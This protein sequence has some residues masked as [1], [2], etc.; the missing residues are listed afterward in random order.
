MEENKN[1]NLKTNKIYFITTFSIFFLIFDYFSKNYLKHISMKYFFS[2]DTTR[3]DYFIYSD[4]FEEGI[5]YLMYYIAYNFINVYCSIFMIAMITLSTFII[6]NLKII[7]RELKPSLK[8]PDFPSCV[9]FFSYGNPSSTASTIF[10]IFGIF[11]KGIY[12]KKPLKST[13]IFSGFLWFISVFYACLARVLQNS[14]YLNQV[15]YGLVIG[16]VIYYIFFEIFEVDIYNFSQ[17]KDFLEHRWWCV[18]F[19]IFIFFFNTFFQFVITKPYLKSNYNDFINQNYLSQTILLEFLGYYLGIILE[20]IVNFK[21]NNDLFCRYNIKEKNE[22]ELFNSTNDDVSFFRL[23][24]FC[25]SDYYLTK[26]IPSDID[27]IDC[28][29]YTNLLLSLPLIHR[30]LKGIIL[31]FVLKYVIRYLGLSNEDIN[32]MFFNNHYISNNTK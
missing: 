14:L 26:T 28:S 18:F 22:N 5:K 2:K 32:D 25:F 10:L 16:F 30:I 29:S 4:Y 1:Q 23:L 7:Y 21:S 15:I 24:L 19:I 6:S 20:Y 11:Y 17:I 27:F 3:C 8:H 13:K 31:Y 9:T 12:Q